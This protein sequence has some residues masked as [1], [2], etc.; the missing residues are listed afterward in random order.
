MLSDAKAARFVLC[1]RFVS[2][3][4]ASISREHQTTV[5]RFLVDA[6]QFEI[7]PSQ[8]DRSMLSR[9][10]V[11]DGTVS[12]NE[13]FSETTFGRFTEASPHRPQLLP[14]FFNEFVASFR[15]PLFPIRVIQDNPFVYFNFLNFFLTTSP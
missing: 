12:S 7:A 4:V 2:A 10:I 5:I 6:I 8:S 3:S 13:P 14:H 15:T 11:I 1:V 9:S